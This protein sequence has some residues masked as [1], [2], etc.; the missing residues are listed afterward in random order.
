[1]LPDIGL[2]EILV[3]VLVAVLAMKPEDIPVVMHQSGIFFAR[4]QR[5]TAGI[6]AGWKEKVGI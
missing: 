4:I 1:V 6:W 2:A 3:I 5:F